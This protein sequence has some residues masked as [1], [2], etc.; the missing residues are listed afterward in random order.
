[1]R[2]AALAL[3]TA[4]GRLRVRLGGLDRGGQEFLLASLGLEH[5]EFGLLA[6]DLLLGLGLGQRPG[7]LG[8]GAAAA[9]SCSASAWRSATSREALI[10]ICSASACLTADSWSA[11]AWAIL[12]SRVTGA[13]FCRPELG[14]VPRLVLDRLDREGVDLDAGGGEVQL[15]AVLD[16]LQELLA[17]HDQLFDRER[18]HD[19]AQRALEHVLD[20]VVD[21]GGV[22]AQ[23]TLG[24]VADRLDVAADLERGHAFDRAP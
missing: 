10:L 22:G 2:D 9:V 4:D 20:D 18:A 11:R 8:S 24:G 12:A 13:S 6:H 17:V 14:D 1:M 21:V 16:P 7:L 3:G 19:R 15:G 23:E 5:G